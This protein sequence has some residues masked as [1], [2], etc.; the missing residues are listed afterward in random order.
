M[1][2]GLLTTRVARE[3]RVVV[4]SRNTEVDTC[5]NSVVVQETRNWSEVCKNIE[6]KI[7]VNRGDPKIKVDRE[8]SGI[9]ASIIQ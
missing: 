5:L 3:T 4:P 2:V 8:D 9:T 6:P 7:E 1:E